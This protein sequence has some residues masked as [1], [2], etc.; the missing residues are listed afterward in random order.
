MI[1][2]VNKIHEEILLIEN[3]VPVS[4]QNAIFER[5]HGINYFPWYLLNKIGH[6]DYKNLK[7]VDENI[8]DESGFYHMIYDEN[9][10]QSNYYDFFRSLLEFYSE[11]TDK[12]IERILRIRAR[13]T[14]PITGHN[15]NKYAAPHVDFNS[16]IPYTTLVYYVNDSDGDTILFDKKF[17]KLSEEYNPIIKEDLKEVFRLAPKKGNA[18]KFDGH[19][20]HAGNFPIDYSSR[21]VINFDFI[22][23]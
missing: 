9:I 5:M 6:K 17:D 7:Y 15:K 19:R 12:Q 13:Y 4:F 18:L 10:S 14:H 16:E 20:Y 21:I 8:T 11:K 22:E 1:H 3:L 23:K 2:R